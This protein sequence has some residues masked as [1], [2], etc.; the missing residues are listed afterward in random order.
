MALPETPLTRGE[1]YL[2]KAAGQDTAIPNVPLTRIEQYLAKIAGQD[3]AIP[4]VPLTRLEQYL[5]AIAENGG[6][7]SITV[8]P[9]TVTANGTQTAPSGKAYSPVT[10]NVPNSYTDSDIGK[11]VGI[12]HSLI[13]QGDETFIA[14][15][16]Y[17]TTYTKRVTVDVQPSQVYSANTAM[18]NPFS[19]LDF[20]ELYANIRD[21]E[22]FGSLRFEFNSMTVQ[23]EL[24]A[25][26]NVIGGMAFMTSPSPVGVLCEWDASGVATLDALMSGQVQ[27]MSTYAPQLVAHVN[28]YGT[29]VPTPAE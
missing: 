14:N 26:R 1:Q 11:A 3:V 18:S 24:Y 23:V 29:T 20:D 13:D 19:G 7:S 2:A 8:E 9:L 6:G 10:V 22:V 21:R 12:G 17:D 28:L 15:R 25:R 4:N 5:A 27:D 16:E